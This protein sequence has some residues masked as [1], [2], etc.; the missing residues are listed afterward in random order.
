MKYLQRFGVDEDAA[1]AVEYCVMLALIVLACIA[2]ISLTGG[3]TV[4]F[5][6]RNRDEIGAALRGS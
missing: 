5:W 2:S 3:E 1:T 6:G 4:N